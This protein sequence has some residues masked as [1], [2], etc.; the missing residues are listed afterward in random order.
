MLSSE[1]RNEGDAN[2]LSAALKLIDQQTG[3][4]SS[5]ADSTAGNR[6]LQN[7]VPAT[8]RPAVILIR[9]A[10][11]LTTSSLPCFTICAASGSIWN[12]LA[13]PTTTG[14]LHDPE[15][16]TS[17]CLEFIETLLVDV[18][19]PDFSDLTIIGVTGQPLTCAVL[20]TLDRDVTVIVDRA[21]GL[22]IARLHALDFDNH[23]IG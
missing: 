19:V 22:D 2:N 5:A 20:R 3:K 23:M 1:T 11:T 8:A 13:V 10:K 4:W 6:P 16:T 7:L 12:Q 9:H 17:T 21:T 18:H 15:G 14:E